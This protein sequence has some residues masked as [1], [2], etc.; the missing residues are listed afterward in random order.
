MATIL[1][2]LPRIEK[3][4]PQGGGLFY[5][6]FAVVAA[7]ENRV[8]LPT[9]ALSDIAVQ[10]SGA[11]A[12]VAATCHDPDDLDNAI[13]DTWDGA[14]AFSLAITALKLTSASTGTVDITA[15]TFKA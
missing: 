13:W 15:R 3:S 4:V 2:D 10:T 5:K 8:V 1:E 14:S 6:R 9:Q 11:S 12:V 7:D